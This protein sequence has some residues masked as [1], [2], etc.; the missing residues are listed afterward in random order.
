[1]LEQLIETNTSGLSTTEFRSKVVS[2]QE[3]MLASD[4]PNIAKGNSDMFPLTHSFSEGVYIREMSM[5]KGGVV[6]G[7]IHNISHTWFLMKGTII[8]ATEQGVEEFTAPTY[9]NAVAGAKRVIYAVE[10]S[11]FINVHPNPDN[12]T[13]TDKL[14]DILTCKDYKEYEEFK[15]KTI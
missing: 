6:I 12:I 11:V 10:K 13:D 7:K 15:N 8:V 14:E 4:D 5:R 9:V 1:M 2:L 3:Q